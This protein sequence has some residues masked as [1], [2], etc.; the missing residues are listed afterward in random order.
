MKMP[1]LIDGDDMRPRSHMDVVVDGQRI[2]R[3]FACNSALDE[4]LKSVQ[5]TTKRGRVFSRKDFVPLKV[6]DIT[7]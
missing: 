3:V 2:E 1:P 4:N 6:E 5:F 7:D